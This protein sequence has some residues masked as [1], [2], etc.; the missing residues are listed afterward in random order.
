MGAVDFVLRLRDMVSGPAGKASAALGRVSASFS[1]VNRSSDRSTAAASKHVDRV[2][3][4]AGGASAALGGMARGAALAVGALALGAAVGIGRSVGQAATFR[5]D[6]MLALKTLLRSQSAAEQAFAKARATAEKIGQDP[7]EVLGAYV[8]LLGKGLDTSTV[9]QIVRSMADLKVV[10]PNANF[11]GIVRAIG[12]IKGAGRL[13]GDELNQLAEAGISVDT[14]YEQLSKQIG[15]SRDEVRKLQAAGKISASQAI[16]GIL[17]GINATVGGGDAGAAAATR[18]TSTISGIMDTIKGRAVGLVLDLEVPGSGAV[19]GVLQTIASSLDGTTETG[20]RLRSVLGS[21]LGAVGALVGRLLDAGGGAAFDGIM[22]GLEMVSGLIVELVPV[23]GAFAQGWVAGLATAGPAVQQIFAALTGLAHVLAANHAAI[24][25]VAQVIAGVMVVGLRLAGAAAQ[26]FSASIGVVATI[27]GAV[28]SAVVSVGGAVLGLVEVFVGAG[29]AIVSAV[30]S[31]FYGA[32]GFLTELPA[33]ASQLGS[34][35]IAG[36]VSG[37]TAGAQ[38]V[39]DAVKRVA[40]GAIDTAKATL[41]IKS[42]SREFAWIGEQSAKG[43]QIGLDS[44]ADGP[45]AAAGRIA[46]GSLGAAAGG[47]S[48]AAGGGSRVEAGAVQITIN[49]GDTAQ[50][51]AAV[52]QALALV[53]ERAAAS[54]GVRAAA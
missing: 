36:L 24:S 25:M 35:I 12:Q 7:R 54:A 21:V 2:S 40:G 28:A 10:S 20:Q 50:V 31:S 29:S 53:L 3:K 11:E 44:A 15:K 48:G 43:W 23:V 17:A 47:A 14:I 38:A 41:G 8:D 5:E 51:R 27:F 9:D 49:G 22:S 34:D 45:A 33:R 13:Q 18:A 37:I 4:S 26:A 16:S 39:A 19:R 32:V 6:T 42:P 52:E 1:G 30:V 46:G